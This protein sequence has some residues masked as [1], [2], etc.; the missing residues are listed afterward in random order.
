MDS[1][2]RLL[3]PLRHHDLAL[4]RTAVA[5]VCTVA[6]AVLPLAAQDSASLVIRTNVAGAQV[7]V[8][9]EARGEAPRRLTL[10]P[11]T[12]T[13]RVEKDG[14]QPW[15][16][17]V[18]L[19]AGEGRTLIARLET[20]SGQKSDVSPDELLEQADRVYD[21][22]DWS[23]AGAAYEQFLAA[24]PDHP[25]ADYARRL[26]GTAAERLQAVDL[27]AAGLALLEQE[28]W[29]RALQLAERALD[30]D[31]ANAEALDLRNRAASS[32]LA[33]VRR[34][35]AELINQGRRA[36]EAGDLSA[37]RDHAQRALD[38]DPTS[39]EA[40]ELRDQIATAAESARGARQ[41][42]AQL[43]IRRGRRMLDAE[44]W[45][46]ALG[47]ASRALKLDP[48]NSDAAGLLSSADAALTATRRL[49]ASIEV[50]EDEP[51]G[52]EATSAEPVSSEASVAA[53]AVQLSKA[54]TATVAT[55][56]FVEPRSG[57]RFLRIPAGAFEMGCTSADGNC[58]A[59]ERPPHPVSL[60]RPFYLAETETTR[61]QYQSCI[62]DRKCPTLP[63]E[64]SR[65]EPGMDHPIQ[66]ASWRDATAFCKWLG[67]RLPTEAEWEYAARGGQAKRRY[68]WGNRPSRDHAN[69]SG[70]QGHDQW[71]KTSP[72]KSFPANDFGLYDMLGNVWEWVADWH[73]GHYYSDSPPQDPE[74]PAEGSSRT[75]R[76]GAAYNNPEYLRVSDRFKAN[77]RIR[78]DYAGIRCA[79]DE[80]PAP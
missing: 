19:E 50:A 26:A 25:A 48:E 72:V 32:E 6:L 71:G 35:T 73:N 59:D 37:A 49:G 7:I 79:L 67:G 39:P 70:R 68:H 36:L 65:Q 45:Q 33:A 78:V 15:E 47:F 57:V 75:L 29:E 53:P 43:M 2:P 64:R 18:E 41:Q 1:R 69:Y 77:P 5:V 80:P 44:A 3:R 28:E 20:V 62:E 17:W 13:I 46:E 76:G 11:G 54:A 21:E 55:G 51:I 10:E 74:G 9:G 63:A 38:T 60:S 16:D 40:M 24:A 31:P 23:G 8:D 56:E 4:S 61:A 42:E 52:V 22:K 66:P 30:L 58:G 27:T 12:H 14:Y 34:Q